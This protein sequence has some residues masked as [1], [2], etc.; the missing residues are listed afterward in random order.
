[1]DAMEVEVIFFSKLFCMLLKFV[2]VPYACVLAA[3]HSVVFTQ[4]GKVPASGS[5]QLKR[6]LA[7]F[8]D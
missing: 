1:M 4:K 7:W 5:S 8:I 3:A 2:V 6:S